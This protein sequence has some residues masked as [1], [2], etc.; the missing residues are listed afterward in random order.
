[1]IAGHILQNLVH[2]YYSVDINKDSAKCANRPTSKPRLSKIWNQQEINDFY[3]P[4]KH[5]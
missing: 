4:E 2:V 1:M 3:V 5:A